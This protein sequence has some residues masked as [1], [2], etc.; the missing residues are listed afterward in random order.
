MVSSV[1]TC[2]GNYKMQ[3]GAPVAGDLWAAEEASQLIFL[4][5]ESTS[6]W[7]L[8]TSFT[9]PPKHHQEKPKR[10]LK[11]CFQSTLIF[12]QNP[13]A[14]CTEISAAFQD[15]ALTSGKNKF[16]QISGG[17]SLP[18]LAT[19]RTVDDLVTSLVS[20]G[21]PGPLTLYS[22][23]DERSRL[24]QGAQFLV[25]SGDVLYPEDCQEEITTVEVAVKWPLFQYNEDGSLDLTSPRSRQQVHDMYLEIIALRNKSLRYHRDIVDLYGWGLDGTWYERPLLVLELAYADLSSIF[26]KHELGPDSI[27]QLSIDVGQGLDAIHAAGIVHGDLK[28]Q[29]ILVFRNN[30]CQQVPFI[31]KLADFGLSVGDHQSP[32]DKCIEVVGMS[33][34]W[35]AP[36][37]CHGSKLTVAQLVKADNFSYGMVLWSIAF[38]RGHPPSSKLPG[39]A[40]ALI[41]YPT[42]F[43]EAFASQ[44]KR[45][46]PLLLAD[47]VEARPFERSE[48]LVS[49][50][51]ARPD[52]DEASRKEQ[53]M[54]EQETDSLQRSFPIEPI[55]IEPLYLQGLEASYRRYRPTL[56]APQL[57][58][59]FLALTHGSPTKSGKELQ[60]AVLQAAISR[61]SVPAQA[62]IADLCHNY[63]VAFEIDTELLQDAVRTGSLMAWRRLHDTAPKV[64]ARAWDQ[65]RERTGYNQ[66][67]S[68][69][70]AIAECDL[71]YRDEYQNNYLHIMAATGKH[72]E[73]KSALKTGDLRASINT[74][75][76]FGETALYK[77]CLAGHWQAVSV[78]CEQGADASIRSGM[79]GLTCLHWLFSFSPAHIRTILTALLKAGANIEACTEPVSWMSNLH[80][81]FSW[82]PGS[83]LHWAIF[84]GCTIATTELL[85]KGANPNARDG[86]DPYITDENVRVMRIHGNAEEGE[87]SE[88]DDETGGFTVVDLAAAMHDAKALQLIRRLSTHPIIMSE[89]EEGYTPIHRLSYL[90][91]SRTSNKLRFWYPAF[92]GTPAERKQKIVETIQELQKMGADIDQLTKTPMNPGRSLVS[93][94]TPLMI[95]VTETDDIATSALLQCGADPNIANANGATALVLLPDR[96]HDFSDLFVIID[97]LV[98]SGANT[99]H[100]ANDGTTPL[101]TAARR[102]GTLYRHIINAGADLKTTCRGIN[103]LAELLYSK[104]HPRCMHEGLSTSEESLAQ[105]NYLAQLIVSK[106][107]DLGIWACNVDKDNGSLLHYA[108]ASGLVKCVEVLIAAGLDV[109]Q[110]R[111]NHFSGP[112]TPRDYS[113]TTIFIGEG[114]PLDVGHETIGCSVGHP[115]WKDFGGCRWYKFEWVVGKALRTTTFPLAA[116]LHAFEEGGCVGNEAERKFDETAKIAR[117]ERVQHTKPGIILHDYPLRSRWPTNVP[118]APL[119]I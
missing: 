48:I 75:N 77:A 100:K 79:I 30:R 82:P 36:E 43:P 64:A 1:L 17:N 69:L 86:R 21:V 110:V 92:V 44:L 67:Y 3:W 28:P 7:Y 39:D 19:L 52:P 24:G 112:S 22:R 97:L 9:P 78:L 72:I 117:G 70:P 115:G 104:S 95:A 14:A 55:S 90:R 4:W 93:G 114:T 94:L 8:L 91:M 16:S 56:T 111:K 68:P 6:I 103:V 27:H 46:L 15:E 20:L 116:S 45:G 118:A 66:F 29:N 102:A 88:S 119:V 32:L 105:D 54:L 99:N 41:N 83:P 101:L 60:L 89:D 12:A 34:Q 10:T 53:V 40:M 31:A 96:S 65:F 63:G 18:G 71:A 47:S 49:W 42:R 109:N 26:S 58:S 81:P 80:F 11:C 13:I 5:T 113:S 57:L 84:T 73:L 108:A 51:I 74:C 62:I 37:I 38:L 2:Q 50:G 35:C 98:K 106:I 76:I 25:T 23:F 61:G 59:L 85:M 107:P 33:S 87:Y